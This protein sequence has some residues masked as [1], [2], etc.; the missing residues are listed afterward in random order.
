[1][2]FF[3][4]KYKAYLFDMDG[5]IVDN[6]T[7]HIDS[8]I[9]FLLFHNIVITREDFFQRNH[10]NLI[11]VMRRFFGE[12]Y[13]DLELLELGQKKEEMYR[14]MYRDHL[15][16]I[17]GC[18][19]F[20][21]LAK[22]SNI[23]LGLATMG[24]QYNIDFTLSGLGINNQFDAITG[25]HEVKNGKP[26]PEVFLKTAQKLGVQPDECLVFEDSKIGVLAAKSAGMKVVGISTMHTH[27]ELYNAG[28]TWVINDYIIH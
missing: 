21:K 12:K 16:E 23:L 6:M 8:W 15:V 17:K 27:Q 13:S 26:H 22:R 10:G 14:Q 9:E 20:L 24:D 25:G 28:C 19:H 2:K 1:M 11:E 5:T 7:Y 3:T 4:Q 18:S